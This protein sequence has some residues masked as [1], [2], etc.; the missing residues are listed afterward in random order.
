MKMIRL[1][2]IMSWTYRSRPCDSRP[3]LAKR[4]VLLNLD[5][6]RKVEFIADEGET[7]VIDGKHIPL[8]F[9]T[10]QR[11][12]LKDAVEL[13]ELPVDSPVP[14]PDKE[15]FNYW[16]P[17]GQ[18]RPPDPPYDHLYKKEKSVFDFLK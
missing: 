10:I 15:W 9:E 7:V 18:V 17:N 4:G 16:F 1:P 13:S 11:L 14:D 6:V 2:L 8:K 5:T 3:E 12:W